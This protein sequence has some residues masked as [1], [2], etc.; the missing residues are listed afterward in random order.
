MPFFSSSIIQDLEAMRNTGLISLAYYYFDYKDSEKQ[1]RRGLLSSLLLQLTARSDA[2]CD[3]L[4]RLHLN[5]DMGLRQPSESDLIKC[6]KMV[7]ALPGQGKV[8]IIMDAVDE[9]PNNLGIPTSRQ[10]VSKLIDEL[11]SLRLPHVRI[12]ITSRPEI[13]IQSS[14][15]RLTSH[16]VS[17]HDE[18]GQRKDII[19]YLK[20]VVVSDQNMAKW[21]EEDKQLVV[22]TLAQKADGMYGLLTTTSYLDAYSMI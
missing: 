3:I 11:V 2:F 1:H 10:K 5:C 21:R 14:L 18:R 6:L 4:D 19:N 7:L 16:C 12:C 22:N 13:D 15:E 8:Y 20:H 17:L 9:C